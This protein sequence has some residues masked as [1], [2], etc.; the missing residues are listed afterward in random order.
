MSNK[1]IEA[2]L[3]ERR[4]CVARDK[5]ERVKAIDEQLKA[6]GYSPKEAAAVEPAETASV[7]KPRKRKA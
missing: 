4:S 6:L 2:L 7:S 3:D 5:K 1:L